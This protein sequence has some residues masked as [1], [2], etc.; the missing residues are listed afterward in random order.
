M[1]EQLPAA[2]S[3]IAGNNR[4]PCRGFDPRLRSYPLAQ[5]RF[6]FFFFFFRPT[7]A[8]DKALATNFEGLGLL[9][10]S[11]STTRAGGSFFFG[12]TTSSLSLVVVPSVS[13]AC[14]G[15]ASS[16]A[17]AQ[18]RAAWKAGPA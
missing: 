8:P 12:T 14:W 15:S 7:S 3:I 18:G 13:R 2:N 11:G 9:G 4:T 17:Q 16:A 5:L 6:F 1:S 10:A